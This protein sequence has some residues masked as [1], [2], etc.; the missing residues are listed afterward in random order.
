MLAQHA[1]DADAPP[2]LAVAACILLL[3]QHLGK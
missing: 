3:P 2:P 1:V